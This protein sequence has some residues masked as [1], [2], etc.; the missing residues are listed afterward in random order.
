[1]GAPQGRSGQVRKISPSTGFDPRT[2]QPVVS[3]YT[4]WAI[5]AHMETAVSINFVWPKGQWILGLQFPRENIYFLHFLQARCGWD[6]NWH[7]GH[8][9]LSEENQDQSIIHVW[10]VYFPWCL[11]VL[12][13]AHYEEFCSF[14]QMKLS[15]GNLTYSSVFK[16]SLKFCSHCLVFCNWYWDYF[17]WKGEFR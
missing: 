7:T 10:N 13:P 11:A 14:A 16:L 6:I 4:N 1:M 8:C 15:F 12:F 2:V 5:P 17:V 9:L 3:C